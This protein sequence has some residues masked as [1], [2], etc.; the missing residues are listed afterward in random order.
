MVELECGDT[1]DGNGWLYDVPLSFARQRD[2]NP[3]VH[4]WKALRDVAE[5]LGYLDASAYNRACAANPEAVL[6]RLRAL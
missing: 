5:H 3:G 6:A 2:V 4:H 1:R